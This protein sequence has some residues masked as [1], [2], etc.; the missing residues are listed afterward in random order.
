[1]VGWLVWL[2]KKRPPGPTGCGKVDVAFY[3]ERMP[4][5]VDQTGLGFGLEADLLVILMRMVS[6][7]APCFGLESGP[8]WNRLIATASGRASP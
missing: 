5:N 7:L 4:S 2:L 1:M 8:E 3:N 6:F